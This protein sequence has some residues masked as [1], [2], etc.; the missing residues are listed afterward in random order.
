[1]KRMV[2]KNGK[3]LSLHPLKFKEMIADV[4]MVKPEQ[5]KSKRNR[6]Q[7]NSQG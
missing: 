2:E 7:K 5:K 3:R 4:L 1:M 6:Q